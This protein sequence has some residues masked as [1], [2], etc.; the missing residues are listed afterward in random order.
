ML[1]RVII[2]ERLLDLAREFAPGLAKFSTEAREANLSDA[3]LTSMAAVRF[4]L[5]IEASFS[6][7]IP[8]GELMPE[9]FASVAAIQALVERLLA[10]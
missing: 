8:D 3:G 6:L 10:N 2:G 4:M 7:A 1:D 5:A 9:N